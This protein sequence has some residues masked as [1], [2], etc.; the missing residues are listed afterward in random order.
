MNF[1]ELPLGLSG[2]V[3][4]SVMPFGAYDREGKLIQ[5]YQQVG[6]ETVIVLAEEREIIAQTGRNLIN[7]YKELGLN[8]DYA[9]IIDFGVPDANAMRA[10][11]EAMLNEARDGKNIAIHCNA[12]KGR[13]GVVAACL[14]KTVFHFEGTE[15]VDWVR[16][17]IPGAIETKEQFDFV[18]AYSA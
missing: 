4:R 2:K 1:T 16:Q 8:V 12:G 14:A 6:I 9:P 15:A 13:T 3:Y 10:T 17:L 5:R 18:L 7:F 11:I